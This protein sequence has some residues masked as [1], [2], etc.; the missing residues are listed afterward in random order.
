MTTIDLNAD[1]GEGCAFDREILAL[2]SSCNIACGGHAG[3]RQTM[4]ATAAKAA[5]EGVAIG[6]HPGYPDPAN[7]GRESGFIAGDALRDSLVA[8]IAALMEVL[9]QQGSSLA[10]VKPH[11]ALYNDAAADDELATLVVLTIGDCCPGAALVGPPQSALSKAANRAGV[12]FLAEAFADRGY[13][14][15]GSLVPRE[16]PGAVLSNLDAIASRALSLVRTGSVLSADGER[17][18]VPADTLCLHGDTP[19]ALDIARAVREHLEANGV[20]IRAVT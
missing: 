3:D 6:A 18:P 5:A 1:L 15:D 10:H 19:Q 4:V 14:A 9:D 2:V 11:G 16:Q 20:G 7:F 12:R 8:Q 17:I 13:N